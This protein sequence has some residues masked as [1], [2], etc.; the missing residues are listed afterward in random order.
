MCKVRHF[1]VSLQ[2]AALSWIS[3]LCWCG[4]RYLLTVLLFLISTLLFSVT[5]TPHPTAKQHQHHTHTRTHTHIMS[6][7][8]PLPVP[9]PPPKQHVLWLQK[10][11]IRFYLPLGTH[12]DIR[13][14]VWFK[15]E[16]QW[17]QF[18]YNFSGTALG[19]MKLPCKS[20]GTTIKTY[21]NVFQILLVNK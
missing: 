2:F 12:G 19:P 4:P 6:T 11:T 3:K 10:V 18:V 21:Q 15:Y 14:S 5:F 13:L 17:F 16:W 8:K 20:Q 1:H 7:H 9:P